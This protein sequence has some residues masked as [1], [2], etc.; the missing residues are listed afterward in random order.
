MSHFATL[1]SK[2]MSTPVLTIAETASVSQAYALLRDRRVSCVAVT[3]EDDRGV[4]VLSRTDLLRVG[5]VEAVAKGA[6]GLLALPDV[7]VRTVMHRSIIAVSP[8]AP[9]G[10]AARTMVADR[11]HRVFVMDGQKVVG[12]L[13]TKDVLLAVRDTHVVTPLAEVMSKP[14]YTVAARTPLSVA[15]ERL[16][17][18][19]VMGLCVV[20]EDRWPVGT[21]TQQ[22]ALAARD[23]PGD[24]PVEEVMSYAMLCLD[25]RVPLFQ[26]AARASATRARRVL[27]VQ[28]R[29]L[30]GVITG[31]D[32][33]RVASAA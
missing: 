11:V 8:D 23:L 7:P 2:L 13:S 31:L 19:R 32:F 25:A 12:V 29:R 33:A 1:V 20:D 17:R 10:S 16:Q 18:A 26:A 4:G 28:D 3:A 14:P 27:V 22:E 24:T 6:P 15:L 30:Q 9:V 21:F 5:R